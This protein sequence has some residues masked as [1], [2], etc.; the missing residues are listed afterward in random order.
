MRTRLTELIA[1]VRMPAGA[2]FSTAANATKDRIYQVQQNAQAA[3]AARRS[4]TTIEQSLTLLHAGGVGLAQAETYLLRKTHPP[5]LV[6]AVV[7]QRIGGG[8]TGG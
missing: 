7:A 5:Q 4:R 2:A 1:R 3:S 8:L 6:R